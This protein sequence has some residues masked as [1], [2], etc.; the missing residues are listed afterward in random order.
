M[1]VEEVEPGEESRVRSF[2]ETI[3]Q[4]VREIILKSHLRYDLNV[5]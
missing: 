5:P 4:L 3:R 2:S 1:W